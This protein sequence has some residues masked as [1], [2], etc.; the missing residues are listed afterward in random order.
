MVIVLDD[1]VAVTPAGNPV[2]IP[3]PEAPVVV[4]II[5][6]IGVLMQSE[7][8]L[9]AELTVAFELTVNEALEATVP[10]QPPVTVY[11]ML[12]VPAATAVTKHDAF[13]VA[14]EVLLL[15]QVPVPPP[16]TVPET[17]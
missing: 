12:L 9:E 4:W 2:A 3:M 13:T 15:L 11:T 5:F 1:Q 7:G 8:E 17:V 14:T 6:V 16:N 10:P